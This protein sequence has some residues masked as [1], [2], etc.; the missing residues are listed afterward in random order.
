METYNFS[1]YEIEDILNNHAYELAEII[2]KA[3]VDIE[4]SIREDKKDE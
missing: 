2:E 1:S 3:Y 4:N